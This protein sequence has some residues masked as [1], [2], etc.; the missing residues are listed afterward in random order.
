MPRLA[1]RRISARSRS[2]GR[3]RLIARRRQHRREGADQRRAERL[4]VDACPALRECSA[5]SGPAPDG[6]NGRSRALPCRG[7]RRHRHSHA[8]LARWCSRRACGIHAPRRPPD[9]N[10]RPRRAGGSRSRAPAAA[11]WRSS[12][13][14]DPRPAPFDTIKEVRTPTLS[15]FIPCNETTIADR[16]RSDVTMWH[17]ETA[18]RRCEPD[19]NPD[20]PAWCRR[21]RFDRR[22]R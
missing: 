11:G 1:L 17:G 19:R 20:S 13:A 10:S 14:L 21:P 3:A 15:S 4:L 12:A 9:Y 8:V 7:T 18:Y 5:R 16:Q 6:R 22:T 2:R